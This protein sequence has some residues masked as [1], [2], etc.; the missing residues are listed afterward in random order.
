MASAV[1]VMD[2]D[3]FNAN[4]DVIV[5]ADAAERRLLWIPRDVW[6]VASGDRVN[7]AYALGG[8]AGLARALAELGAP[9]RTSLCL[10]PRAV[11]AAIEGLEVEV[12]VQREPA[13]WYPLHPREPIEDGRREIR[14]RPPHERLSGERIEQWVGARY[15]VDGSATD[16][17]RIE[18]QQT[19]V[20]ALLAGGFD[21]GR[22][23]EDPGGSRVSAPAV[24]E[25]LGAV[26]ADWSFETL[27]EL[28]EATI[29]DKAV[30]LW[31]GSG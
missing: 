11:G 1:A 4:T 9:I 26:G 24:I 22:A 16:L 14:F 12:P 21:F 18:R 29:E 2:R 6:S 5:V 27:G 3:A 7:R 17:R 10:L 15:E 19:L 13:F 31:V 8:H 28:A 25:E 23:L 20:R 30:L